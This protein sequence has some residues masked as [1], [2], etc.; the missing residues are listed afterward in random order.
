MRGSYP[1]SRFRR[2][3]Q[4]RGRVASAGEEARARGGSDL[5]AGEVEGSCGL[6]SLPRGFT[7]GVRLAPFGW[8]N[9]GLAETGFCFAI[10]PQ[11]RDRHTHIA[12]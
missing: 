3:A 9:S 12:A 5:T 4:R 6:W 2:V 10:H 1:I 7:R 8:G 11:N